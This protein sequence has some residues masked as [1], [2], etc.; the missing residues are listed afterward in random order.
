MLEFELQIP[1]SNLHSEFELRIRSWNSEFKCRTSN[2][3]HM[4]EVWSLEKIVSRASRNCRRS[5][6]QQSCHSDW[7]SHCTTGKPHNPQQPPQPL[8]SYELFHLLPPHCFCLSSS[9]T[10]IWRLSQ[11]QQKYPRRLRKRILDIVPLF[12]WEYPNGFWIFRCFWILRHLFSTII[13]HFV[14]A[15]P[16]TRTHRILDTNSYHF[17]YQLLLS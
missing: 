13:C 9:L 4:C 17:R 11:T 16:N 5:R 8:K 14:G 10:R 2:K 6:L 3:N 15:K 1:N 12:L 7:W